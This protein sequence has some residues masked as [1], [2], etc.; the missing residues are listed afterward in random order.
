MPVVLCYVCFCMFHLETYKKRE[1]RGGGVVIFVCL[2]GWGGG[3]GEEEGWRTLF[4]SQVYVLLLTLK[5]PF[6]FGGAYLQQLNYLKTM[7][8][9]MLSHFVAQIQHKLFLFGDLMPD[10]LYS[11]CHSNKYDCFNIE[12][13]FS[14]KIRILKMKIFEI[15][16]QTHYIMR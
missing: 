7:L 1:G 5:L 16:R 14:L 12:L 13:F 4:F 10:T 8:H 11:F 6:F 2:R 15:S 3:L 9:D